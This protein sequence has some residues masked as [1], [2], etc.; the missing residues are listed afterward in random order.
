MNRA[1]TC[2]AAFVF[3]ASIVST[4]AAQPRVDRVQ[5][6]SDAGIRADEARALAAQAVER[7]AA[8][9]LAFFPNAP[10]IEVKLSFNYSGGEKTLALQSKAGNGLEETAVLYW[11]EKADLEAQLS[12]MAFSLWARAAGLADD[13]RGEAPKPS[14]EL[15]AARLATAFGADESMPQA[16]ASAAPSPSG[17]VFLSGIGFLVELGPDFEPRTR[18]R[19][20][21]ANP[22]QY[23][24][25]MASSASGAVTGMTSSGEFWTLKLGEDGFKRSGNVSPLPSSFVLSP[26]G[27]PVFQDYA[28]GGFFSLNARRREPVRLEGAPPI[29]MAAL[30]YDDDGNLWYYDIVSGLLR[31]YD[32][33]GKLSSA[34]RLVMPG[35][36]RPAPQRLHIRGSEFILADSQGL[37]AFDRFGLPLWRLKGVAPAADPLAASM[38]YGSSVGR[39]GA[40]YVL[41]QGG[42]LS[43]TR[44]DDRRSLAALRSSGRAD[45][46]QALERAMAAN[47]AVAEDPDDEGRFAARAELFQSLGYASV[48]L[49]M[50]A[51]MAEAFPAAR[52]NAA[53]L[54]ELRASIVRAQ[55]LA[56]AEAVYEPLS[57][58]GAETAR[59]DYQK[60]MRLLERYLGDNPGDEAAARVMSA[61]GDAFR[62]REGGRL[63]GRPSPLVIE[64]RFDPVFPAFMERYRSVPVGSVTVR[65]AGASPAAAVRVS[66]AIKD[67]MDFPAEFTL[68]TPLAPGESAVVPV[69]LPL[70]RAILELREEL[71]VSALV[72]AAAEGF[73]GRASAEIRLLSRNALTW[74]DTAALAAFVTPN[75][76]LIVAFSHAALAFGPPPLFDRSF[77]RAFA[78]ATALGAR[79][80]VYAEDP[81]TPFSAVASLGGA[82]RG[83]SGAG[84]AGSTPSA[85]P[86]DTVRFPRATLSSGGGDC[87]DT[88]AL[89]ASCLEAVGVSVAILTTPGHVLIAFA[90][91]A[92][93]AGPGRYGLPGG[94][95]GS[96]EFGGRHWIPIE[97][98][99]LSKGFAEAWRLG[100]A[101]AS[102]AGAALE[103]VPLAEARRRFPALPLAGTPGDP[104][105]PSAS[106]WRALADSSL[107]GLRGAYAEPLRA[108][109]TAAGGAGGAVTG[110]RA[111]N[112]LGVRLVQLGDYAGAAEAFRQSIRLDPKAA[113]ARANLVVALD[114]A[115]DEAG[116]SRALAEARRELPDDRVLAMLAQRR[117]SGALAEARRAPAD[118]P[119]GSDGSRASG[120][121]YVE[122]I[123]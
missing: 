64:A 75:D 24:Y 121:T 13:W 4:P 98:T 122:L 69:T 37:A 21:P 67:F 2:V 112:D 39:D 45:F 44:Y 97:T 15:S 59:A 18:Y 101:E 82:S 28:A 41:S 8:N 71:G 36:E 116:A 33:A 11:R 49:T 74:D 78:I 91:E 119:E 109:A 73:E 93:P 38:I 12:P 72:T 61:L 76:D 20:D 43:L 40:V 120:G 30:D 48:E 62:A 87:D 58:Y 17:G 103:L 92:G 70:N 85:W 99:V 107:A 113:P 68:P 88:S 108:A 60:A 23:L 90:A 22:Y 105:A 57:R 94:A 3:A 65:N 34:L 95:Y 47:A 89:L 31:S 9:A 6:A 32:A 100:Y 51:A 14:L 80:L 66:V 96:L 110:G 29:T 86:I 46:A 84:A 114:L 56:A 16:Y 123:W 63:P 79:G 10:K 35:G 42:G 5:V 115:G 117:A 50:R 111:Y 26:S 53:R 83:A 104:P 55:A 1:I 27:A 54:A 81:K 106:A 52:L 25:A 7:A 77:S 102:K 118:G 19:L